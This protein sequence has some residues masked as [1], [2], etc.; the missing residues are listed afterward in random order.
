MRIAALDYVITDRSK[1]GTSGVSDM[2]WDLARGLRTF[3]DEIHIAGPYQTTSYPVAGVA[4]HRFGVPQYWYRNV[5]T[6]FLIIR[7]GAAALRRI[8]D[9]DLVHVPEYV[10]AALLTYMLPN[11]PIVLTTP[12]NIFERIHRFNPYDRLTTLVYAWAARQ[13]ARRCARIVAT[14]NDMASWWRHSGA[15]ADKIVVIPL[16]VDTGAFHPRAD[17][18]NQLGWTNDVQHVLYVGRLARENRVELLMECMREVYAVR[19]DRVRL[20]IVGDGPLRERLEQLADHLGIAG[21]MTW[22]GAIAFDHLPLYYSASDLF[23]FPRP[24]GAPP[25]VVPQAMACGT[26]ILS[27]ASDSIADYVVDGETGLVVDA[28][29]G[30]LLAQ[31]LL[32]ALDQPAKLAVLGQAALRFAREHCAIDVVTRRVRNEVYAPLLHPGQMQRRAKLNCV[33]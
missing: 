3:G 29:D 22:H 19:G 24:T 26:P 4:V 18:R 9:V 17:A 33:E 27:I 8:A 21:A 32:A 15:D 28:V 13:A 31:R 2:T 20:H 30:K 12:G 23:V 25:R 16:A 10:S 6:Q 5:L 14:S 7:K 1:P 11:T